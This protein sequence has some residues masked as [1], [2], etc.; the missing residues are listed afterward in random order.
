M[1]AKYCL[2]KG[3]SVMSDFQNYDSYL[4]LSARAEALSASLVDSG[5]LSAISDSADAGAFY[6]LL[7]EYGI[8]GTVNSYG[9]TEYKSAIISRKHKRLFE[10]VSELDEPTKFAYF[11]Y[12]YDCHNLKSAIKCFERG[13]SPKDLFVPSGSVPCSEI[14]KHVK[15]RDFSAFPENMANAAK[16][17]FTAYEK[18]KSPRVI[19]IL[20]DC[21]CFKDIKEN[22]GTVE[23][24]SDLLK[25]RADG[26][27]I[28]TFLRTKNETLEK[29]EEIIRRCFVVGGTLSSED[30]IN[31][32]K[33]GNGFMELAKKLPSFTFSEVIS[34][35]SEDFIPPL[36]ECER[37]CRDAL[38]RTENK[39]VYIT[40]GIEK[41]GYYITRIENESRQLLNLLNRFKNARR[42]YV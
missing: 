25:V 37:L 30:F 9:E 21:A 11:L 40:T 19:D 27:N 41:I 16:E 12:Q 14:E 7:S 34:S 28:L 39:A 36:S 20:L 18:T 1:Y 10:I 2:N 22:G 8:K 29:K 4:Y 26:I 38:E 32:L 33:D 42:R 5:Q 35:R 13:I 24:F 15:E 3:I 17:A 31:A 23:Y 6:S